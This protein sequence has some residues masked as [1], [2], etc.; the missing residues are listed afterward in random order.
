MVLKK[1]GPS[2]RQ[3]R[4]HAAAVDR[5]DLLALAIGAIAFEMPDIAVSTI[6]S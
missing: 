4:R 5:H 3:I 2:F 1:Y 6:G